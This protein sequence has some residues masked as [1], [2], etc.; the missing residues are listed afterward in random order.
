MSR[1]EG[2]GARGQEGELARLGSVPRGG[3]GRKGA[4]AGGKG[5]PGRE[6]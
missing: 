4:E 5:T 1:H 2:A 3:G 6:D